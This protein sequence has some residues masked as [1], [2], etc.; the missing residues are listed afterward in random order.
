MKKFRDD[1]GYLEIGKAERWFN[2][3]F[4]WYV[5]KHHNET[6]PPCSKS[7]WLKLGLLTITWWEDGEDL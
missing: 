2:P 4:V 5:T 6:V 7:Y 3:F 1:W